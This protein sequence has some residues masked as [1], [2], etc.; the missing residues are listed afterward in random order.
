MD[1]IVIGWLVLVVL[2]C[3]PVVTLDKTGTTGLRSE[4]PNSQA[5]K[6]QEPAAAGSFLAER[7]GFEPSLPLRVNRFSRPTHS[8]T[9]PPLHQ[10]QFL[11]FSLLSRFAL[12]RITHTF[13]IRTL[14][15]VKLPPAGSDRRG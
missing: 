4:G 13:T 2:G 7:E 8:T 14:W 3:D 5:L 9:L 15:G 12:L 10:L 11:A 1:G 6:K